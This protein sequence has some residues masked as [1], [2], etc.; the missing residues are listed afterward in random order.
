MTDPDQTSARHRLDTALDDLTT[1]F[2]DMTAHPDE[3]NCECHWGSAEELALLKTAGVE[4]HPDLLRRTW[5]TSD[6]DD[7]ASVLRRILPQLA[8]ALVT[9]QVLPMIGMVDV[10]RSLTRAD[11]Q[12]W[13]AE[14]TDAV[15]RFLTAWWVSS[16]TS[17]DAA[18]P[19]H[20][21]LEAC[22]ESSATLDPWLAIWQ[23]LHDPLADQRLTE[24][25]AYWEH[26][27]LQD[28]LPWDTWHDEQVALTM[29]ATLTAW[30]VE[31]AP[32]RL[33]AHGAP[34]HLLHRVRLLGL[35]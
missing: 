15:H 19:A 16:L 24:A 21:V 26:D 2:G 32:E 4:L 8:S 7:N 9:G 14:Q 10:G 22:S 5:W 11:W 23:T 35:L 28:D 6:W 27:L 31:H 12:H 25:V 30:L 33:R 29:R 1:V 20:E 18:V 34:E 17:P 3:H 13:P